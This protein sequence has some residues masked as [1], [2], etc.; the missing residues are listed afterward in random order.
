M[1][2]EG[3]TGPSGER[4]G[5]VPMNQIY[6]SGLWDAPQ[7]VGGGSAEITAPPVVDVI[8]TEEEKAAAATQLTRIYERMPQALMAG[9]MGHAAIYNSLGND[10]APPLE[11]RNPDEP[12][13]FRDLDMLFATRGE[14][15]LY[16]YSQTNPAAQHRIDPNLGWFIQLHDGEPLL[17][18]AD[19]Q[20]RDIYIPV[21]P[22][23]VRPMERTLLGAPV[24]TLAVGAQVQL[25]WLRVRR[26]GTDGRRLRRIIDMAVFAERI[27]DTEPQE[28]LPPDAYKPF[29][30]FRKRKLH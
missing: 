24:R 7:T 4:R 23:V 12:S 9:R 20:G 27:Q 11:L 30:E 10:E 29:V 15:S 14:A 26:Y 19:D 5:P 17:H 25:E 28:F 13:G 8:G 16:G 1:S 22:A 21:D 2:S 18:G 3:I 6:V